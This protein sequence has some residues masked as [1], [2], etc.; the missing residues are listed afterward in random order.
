VARLGPFVEPTPAIRP[1]PESLATKSRGHGLGGR[2]QR[3]SRAM[4]PMQSEKLNSWYF[5][6]TRRRASRADRVAARIPHFEL[7]YQ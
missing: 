7:L 4:N 3:K 6:E 5:L 2:V 1:N